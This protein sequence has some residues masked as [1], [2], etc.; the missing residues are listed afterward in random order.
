MYFKLSPREQNIH[1][2]LQVN[3]PKI[4]L[5]C[6]E[7]VALSSGAVRKGVLEEG[8]GS[9]SPKEGDMVGAQK[10]FPQ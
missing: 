4:Y 5:A 7:Q 3:L 6:R 1:L 9:E 8:Q 2:Q 10:C